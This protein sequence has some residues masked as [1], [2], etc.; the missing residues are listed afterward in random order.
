MRLMAGHDIQSSL[1]RAGN[2]RDN[3]V[4]ESFFSSLAR[5]A[6]RTFGVVAACL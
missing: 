1:S 3:A 2:V 5:I 6:A 4:V